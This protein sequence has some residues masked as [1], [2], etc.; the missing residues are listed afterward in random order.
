MMDQSNPQQLPDASRLHSSC[1]ACLPFP[2]HQYIL[3]IV[4][5]VHTTPVKLRSFDT[6]SVLGVLNQEILE[7]FV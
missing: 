1:Y 7:T 5:N 4:I 3:K 2:L 6:F